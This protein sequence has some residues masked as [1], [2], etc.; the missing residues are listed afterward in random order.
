M[1]AD[2]PGQKRSSRRAAYALAA[3]A[4]F[5]VEVLIALFVRDAFV[6]PYGGDVL[7]VALVYA[8]LR[9]VTPLRMWPAIATS[10]AI[11]VLI[12]LGQLVHIL[13]ML[14]LADNKVARIVLGSGFEWLD[15]AA[16]AA[17]AALALG[18]EALL[19]RMRT[20]T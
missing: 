19:D 13:D 16:Y 8:A 6:R 2:A 12:E 15:F 9:A 1:R 17:G 10:F 11:A 5:A 7:A 18:V 4:I 20:R 14:G 3:M